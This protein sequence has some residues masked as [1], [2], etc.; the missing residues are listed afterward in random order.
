MDTI[1]NVISQYKIDTLKPDNVNGLMR[2][3]SAYDIFNYTL[4]EHNGPGYM[5]NPITFNQTNLR[6]HEIIMYSLHKYKYRNSLIK[7]K[8]NIKYN[9]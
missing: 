9:N 7:I 4:N 8:Y 6:Q 1:I 5:I 3:L 2:I